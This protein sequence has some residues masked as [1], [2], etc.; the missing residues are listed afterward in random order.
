[1]SE[2]LHGAV[3]SDAGGVMSLAL[4]GRGVMSLALQGGGVM[5]DA[6]QGG[7]MLLAGGVTVL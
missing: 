5:S 6:L 1:M 4:Q 2:A 7:V 3:R